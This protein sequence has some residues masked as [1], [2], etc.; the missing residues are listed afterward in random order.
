MDILTVAREY[1]RV[2][3]E[4]RRL[5]Q[6]EQ[7]LRLQ[8]EDFFHHSSERSI[9]TDAGSVSWLEIKMVTW[10]AAA[11]KKVL[12]PRLWRTV[13]TVTVNGKMM[14]ELIKSDQ[15]APEDVA[16]CR[17][18]ERRYR[19]VSRSLATPGGAKTPVG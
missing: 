13:T 4:R 1:I 10:D 15:V 16:L 11:L 2:A 6:E 12:P 3:S 18:E 17:R 5:E 19:L 7:A 8:L 9:R 14:E